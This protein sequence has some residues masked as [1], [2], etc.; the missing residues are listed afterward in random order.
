[1]RLHVVHDDSG[2]IVA[3]ARSD[4]VGPHPLAPEGHFGAEVEVPDE[5][6]DLGLDDVCARYRVVRGALLAVEDGSAS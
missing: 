3:A 2:R 1:M 4:E 6:R 5:H